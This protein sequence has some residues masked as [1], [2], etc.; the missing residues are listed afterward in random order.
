MKGRGT[1]SGEVT[2]SG[3]KGK[4]RKGK[5][6]KGKERKGKERKGKEKVKDNTE[7]LSLCLPYVFYS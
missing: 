3:V 1:S 7:V 5:E 2:W 4:E 6:R